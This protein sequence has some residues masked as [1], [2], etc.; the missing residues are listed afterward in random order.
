MQGDL[1]DLQ[2]HEAFVDR[3]DVVVRGQAA[4]GGAVALGDGG[5]VA[6]GADVVPLAHAHRATRFLQ[7]D[8]DTELGEGLDEDLR[9]REGAE[10][11]HGAGPVE[12]GGLQLGGLLVVHG[13]LLGGEVR[14]GCRGAGRHGWG[15]G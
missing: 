3:S 15:R 12:D 9:R 1:L 6:Q 13:C 14:C 10:V 11:D 4:E 7:A 5:D 8:G 2:G